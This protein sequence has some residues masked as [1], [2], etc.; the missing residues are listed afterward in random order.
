MESVFKHSLRIGTVSAILMA[1]SACS[2]V[3]MPNLD[4]LK[5]KDFEEETANIGDYPNVADAPTRPT[6]VRSDKAWDDAAK[7]M[8]TIRDNM[9]VPSDGTAQRSEAEI[10]AEVARLKAKAEA[11]KLDDPQ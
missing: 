5:I 11:Y 1:L 8:M 3:S 6:D 9:V 4:V 7:R 2:T 10:N